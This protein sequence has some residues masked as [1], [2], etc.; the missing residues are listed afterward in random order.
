MTDVHTKTQR[1]YNMSRIRSSKTKAELKLINFFRSLGFKYQPKNVYGKPDFANSRE[2]IAIFVDGCFWHKCPKH[3]IKPKSN[4]KF[5]EEKI[6]KNIKRDREVNKK[7]REIGWK[8]IR[9]W[10][11]ELKT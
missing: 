5:W 3:F 9:I 1:S 11:H 7:L 6:R 10:E 8:I 4:V 2:K